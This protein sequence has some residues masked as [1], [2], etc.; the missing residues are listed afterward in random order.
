MTSP[1]VVGNWK[2]NGS[3]SDSREL[4]GRI[5]TA[6]NSTPTSTHIIIAPPFT[7]L[8]T[9]GIALRGSN[10]QLAGQNCHWQLNGAFTGEVSPSML[11]ELGCRFVILG[12]CERRHIFHETDEMVAQKVSAVMAQG[13]RPILCVGETLAQRQ[14]QQ[15]FEIIEQQ[16]ESALKGLNNGAIETIEIAYEPVWAIGTGQNA[17]PDQIREVH[18]RIRQF[19]SLSFSRLKDGPRILYGGSVNRDNA[20]TIADIGD[21][22]GLLVGGASLQVE[23]FLEIIRA[24]SDRSL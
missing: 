20:R 9:V 19:L 11:A 23:S 16:L 7:A 10:I 2:M 24:F 21:V 14:N 1:L 17:S 12:H 8:A 13:M 18:A 6:L 3:Q 5:A 22:N 4:A 15:T